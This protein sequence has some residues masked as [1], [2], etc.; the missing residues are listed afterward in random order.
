MPWEAISKFNYQAE[1]TLPGFWCCGAQA[2]GQ[3][4]AVKAATAEGSSAGPELSGSWKRH[5]GRW[6]GCVVA[7]LWGSVAWS[8]T[9]CEETSTVRHLGLWGYSHWE[10]TQALRLH[11]FWGNAGSEEIWD[12]RRHRLWGNWALRWLGSEMTGLWGDWAL[13]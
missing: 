1:S 10:T 8:G 13:R 11:G 6:Q 7:G 4:S 3:R 5:P 2:R 12:Q 9:S